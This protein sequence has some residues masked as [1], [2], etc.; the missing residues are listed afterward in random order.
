[1][2]LRLQLVLFLVLGLYSAS[3]AFSTR[4]T[5]LP[6]QGKKSI[7]L[8]K[9][10]EYDSLL[11]SLDSVLNSPVTITDVGTEVKAEVLTDMSHIVLDFSGFFTP[12]K[13]L[14]L[15]GAL[16]GRLM[17]LYMDTFLPGH[18]VPPEELA[19]QMFL[20]GINLYDLLKVAVLEQQPRA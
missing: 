1:M 14:T 17:V 9:A 15:M 19:V 12:S 7:T 18:N 20:F 16:V 5:F 13:S 4:Q 10:M 8:R 11:G 3:N 2:P 6:M